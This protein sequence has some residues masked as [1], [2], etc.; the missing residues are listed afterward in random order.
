VTVSDRQTTLAAKLSIPEDVSYRLGGLY[1]ESSVQVF[2]VRGALAGDNDQYRGHAFIKEC[3]ELQRK[4]ALHM[5]SSVK[6][7]V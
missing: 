4:L 6:K 3:Q 1:P 5:E 2:R 7:L